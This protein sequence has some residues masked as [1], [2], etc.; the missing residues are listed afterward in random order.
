M[1]SVPL[2]EKVYGFMSSPAVEANF[3]V[4]LITGPGAENRPS[5]EDL[6]SS[7]KLSGF[8]HVAFRVGSVDETIAELKHRDVI[9][10]S[11]PHDVPKLGLRVAFFADPWGNLFE[12]IHD[13]NV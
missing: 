10:V 9:I 5:Y 13:I 4:E 11:E 3:M 8:H 7:L 2:G 6:A 1:K 12:V